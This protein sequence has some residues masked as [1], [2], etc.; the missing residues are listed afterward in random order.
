MKKILSALVVLLFVLT[1]VQAQENS[2][3]KSA[4]DLE[5]DQ[6]KAF[7]TYYNVQLESL[8]AHQLE[9][10][11]HSKENQWEIA[12]LALKSSDDASQI[13]KEQYIPNHTAYAGW[14]QPAK[15]YTRVP[16]RF[17]SMKK[18]TRECS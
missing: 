18:N 10:W 15:E 12:L 1:N 9:V 8:S 6:L 2:E 11:Y 4:L 14:P 16:E 13:K 5:I 17:N 3:P 7:R